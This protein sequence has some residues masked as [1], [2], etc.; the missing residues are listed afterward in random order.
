M[1]DTRWHFYEQHKAGRQPVLDRRLGCHATTTF[2]EYSYMPGID[3][4]IPQEQLFESCFCGFFMP[5]FKR[6]PCKTDS[7]W[8]NFAITIELESAEA[9]RRYKKWIL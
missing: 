1:S 8:Q 7:F 5:F 2:H 9:D 3:H 4:L 6:P